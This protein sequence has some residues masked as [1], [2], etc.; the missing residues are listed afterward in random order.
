MITPMTPDQFDADRAEPFDF[1]RETG[2]WAWFEG[3]DAGGFSGP[4]EELATLPAD[5]FVHLDDHDERD[6]SGES[7]RQYPTRAAAVAALDRA[8][9]KVYGVPFVEPVEVSDD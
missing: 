2:R 8:L 4:T 7:M 5:L 1:T 3:C 9:A 6:P